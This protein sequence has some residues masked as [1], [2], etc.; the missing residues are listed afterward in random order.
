MADAYPGIRRMGDRAVVY[1]PPVDIEQFVSFDPAGRG[2]GASVVVG[3]LAN[4]N[5]DKGLEHL[6]DAA[7]LLGGRAG[8]TFEVYGSTHAT[9][10]DYARAL[11]ALADRTPA[12]NFFFRGETSDVPRVLSEVDIFVI[13]SLREGTTTTAIEAMAA[14]LPVVATNVGGIPEV[15]M[16]EETGILVEPAEAGELAEAIAR[17]VEDRDLRFRM[18]RNGR[19][20]AEREFGLEKTAFAFR[21]AYHI[22]VDGRSGS[23]PR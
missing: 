11:A 4:L 5:P 14:G 15:V 6:I 19:T 8:V 10:T 13:S 1:Y 16:D 18:G 2:T 20:R 7:S 22:A 12:R 9:H 17:L 23:S 21:R 3:T